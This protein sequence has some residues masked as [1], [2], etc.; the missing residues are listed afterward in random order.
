MDNK[1]SDTDNIAQT[2]Q[3]LNYTTKSMINQEFKAIPN[4]LREVNQWVCWKATPRKNSTKMDKIPYNPKTGY[5]ALSNNSNTWTSFDKAYSE[6]VKGNY[7]GIGFMFANGYFG[8]DID[9]I[10]ED[11]EKF[12][13]GNKDNIISEFVEGLSSYTE[14]SPSRKGIHV[15]CKGTLP[16]GR[17]RTDNVEM[18]QSGRFFTV[19]GYNIGNYGITECTNKIKRLHKK[20]VDKEEVQKMMDTQY[21]P[22]SLNDNEIIE[23]A[24]RSKNGYKFKELYQGGFNGFDSQSEA[25]I[26]FCFML[27]YWTQR[28]PQQMD[29]IFRSSGLM[30]DKW[31]KRVA[32]STYGARTIQSAIKGC[33]R[34]YNPNYRSQTARRTI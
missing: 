15:I 2:Q 31:N 21:I 13:A 3:Q 33:S 34:V 30:R 23:K 20:Y 14:Y 17:R 19:T 4:E 10:T 29:T 22:L 26:S 12:K 6:Y 16:E 18:Y 5:K 27:A 28:N 8:V 1:K 9:G 32:G 7:N 11:V 24:S 25:D